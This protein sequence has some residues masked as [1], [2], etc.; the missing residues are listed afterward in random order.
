MGLKESGYYGYAVLGARLL[1]CISLVAIIGM[2]SNFI[3][4][5]SKAKQKTPQEL[6]ATLVIN[7][8]AVLW[9]LLSLNA[10][11][12]THI[13]FLV[14]A[15]V[16]VLFLVPF[17]VIAVVLGQPL[18]STT[19]SE[20]PK[21]NSANTFLALPVGNKGLSYVLFVGAQQTTCYELMAVW[22]LIIVLCVLFTA[23]GIA[24]LFLFLGKRRALSSQ[25][26]GRA[27][28]QEAWSDDA[29]MTAP[30]SGGAAPGRLIPQ[31]F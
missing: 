5:L 13:P 24:A 21:T 11:G 9:V 2:V 10:Y 14:T 3:S 25:S 15:A 23:S 28:K 1:Q 29:P 30:L 17:I 4:L 19:C 27:D 8:L 12:D 18:S 6:V 16:D 20:L 7:C 31:G 22:G 26:A